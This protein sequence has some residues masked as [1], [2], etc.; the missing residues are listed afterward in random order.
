MELNSLTAVGPLDGRYRK[1]IE[2]LDRYFS[3]FALIKYR[4]QVEILYFIQLHTL[5]LPQLPLLSPEDEK[6]LHEI[7]QQF[8]L[9]DAESVKA[10]E[11]Q[12]NHDVKAVEYFIKKALSEGDFSE[13]VKSRSEFIH[14]GLTSQDVNNTATPMMLRDALHMVYLPKLE[15]VMKQLEEMSEQYREIPL[16]A[17]TH[18]QPASPTGLGKEIA[19]FQTRLQ[20]Q[21]DGLKAL[22]IKGKFGGATGNMNAHFVAFPDVD[23]KEFADGFVKNILKLSRSY[24]TTQIDPY[25]G[26]AEV[27]DYLKRINTILMDLCQD[28]WIYIS[29][30]YF[31][32]EIKAGEVGSSAMPHKVNPIDFE[33]AEGNCGMSTA[34]LEFFS[35]KLPISR[36]QRDLT[37][38]TVLRNVGVA[39]GYAFLAQQSAL[40]GLRKLKVNEAKIQADLNA[41]QAVLAEAIQTILRRENYPNPYEALRDLTRTNAQISAEVLAKFVETLDVAE[42]VKTE[43][44][45]L[46]VE[47]YVG[48]A[49]NW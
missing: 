4:T 12:T 9:A 38:S 19:V 36:L 7:Y 31:Q 39:V 44:R 11:R 35:R 26:L 10:F 43:I 28:I 17:R 33:N 48:N 18:G 1:K 41:N 2:S 27:F 47:T 22:S 13:E 29:M 46:S 16:L 6:G 25:D 23:W 49:H 3:E 45:Q 32:Q 8:S 5:G 40:K 14:F 37:D 20:S 30:D 42:A 34:I 15:E 21:Y 24:P